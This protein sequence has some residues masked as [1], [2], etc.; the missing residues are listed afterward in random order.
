[1]F[2]PMTERDSGAR[3]YLIIVALNDA[4]TD[5]PDW[6]T[7]KSFIVSST[8]GFNYHASVW[9][10][11]MIALEATTDFVCLVSPLFK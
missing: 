6:K 2:I 1:M 10:H 11:P 8:Q 9:H 3:A 7:L 4:E 5:K